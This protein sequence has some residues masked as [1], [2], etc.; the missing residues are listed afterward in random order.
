MPFLMNFAIPA[1]LWMRHPCKPVDALEGLGSMDREIMEIMERILAMSS[2]PDVDVDEK[3]MTA[4]YFS[5]LV[6]G[7]IDSAQEY[8]FELANG[9]EGDWCPKAAA[10]LENFWREMINGSTSLPSAY[11][12]EHIYEALNG[13][14]GDC[15]N[16][17][18][19]ILNKIWQSAGID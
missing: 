19:E 17:L 10:S 18:G 13:S 15:E 3:W 8:A 2:E 6:I 14:L 11:T 12:V 4:L 5:Q 1:S 16:D 9:S 7:M